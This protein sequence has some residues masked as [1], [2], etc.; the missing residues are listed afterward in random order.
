VTE[1]EKLTFCCGKAIFQ[2]LDYKLMNLRQ[3]FLNNY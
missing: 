1:S 3:W 2:L